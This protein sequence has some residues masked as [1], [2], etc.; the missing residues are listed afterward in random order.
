MTC[1]A[2]LLCQEIL[3]TRI[4]EW[5][6][7]PFFRESSQPRDWT[8]VSCTT[9]R[10]FTVWGTQFSSVAQLCLTL[11]SHG[12]QHA[13]L[14]CHHQ[15]PELAQTH[16]HR[17]GDAFSLSQY[18]GLFQWISSSHQVAKVLRVSASASVLPMNIQYRS[19]LSPWSSQESSPTSQFKVSIFRHSA[20]FMVQLSHPYMTTRKTI[21]LI[22]GCLSA[23]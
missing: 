9:G 14:P 10:C 6:A 16:V 4:L 18:Q 13:R 7:I 22:E 23:K 12:L 17:V 8:W 2:R 5:V 1:P 11:W 21:A 20:F 3:Q 15:L 19:P